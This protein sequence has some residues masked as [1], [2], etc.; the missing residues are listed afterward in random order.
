MPKLL[1]VIVIGAGSAGLSAA[2]QLQKR[3]FRVV[4]LEKGESLTMRNFAA[5]IYQLLFLR[6]SVLRRL[7]PTTL[8]KG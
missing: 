1:D 6:L 5:A 7:L 4:V 2:S 8:L 3:I